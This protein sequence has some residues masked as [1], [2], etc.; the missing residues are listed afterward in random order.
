MSSCVKAWVIVA[1]AGF[2]VVAGNALA[3]ESSAIPVEGSPF[4]ARLTRVAAPWRLEFSTSAGPRELAAADLVAWGGFVDSSHGTE[5]LLE[6]GGL[7]VADVKSLEKETLAC[8][9]DVIGAVKLPLE[10]VTGVLWRPPA[11]RAAHDA[12]H[13]RMREATGADDRVLLDNGDELRGAIAALTEDRLTIDTAA[14]PTRVEL[15]R[16]VAVVFNPSLAART[17]LSELRAML[18]LA[19]G[20]RLLATQLKLTGGVAEINA[21]GVGAIKLGVEQLV[22]RAAARRQGGVSLGPRGRLL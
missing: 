20:S 22:A 1:I 3:A 15:A 19:D 14:G 5:I 9:G 16:V 12:L 17:R 13:R 11:E 21:L 10:S 18:G 4:A 2:R 8:D 7:L 6:G